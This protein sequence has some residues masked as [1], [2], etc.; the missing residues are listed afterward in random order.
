MHILMVYN[1]EN[2]MTDEK[3]PLD[4]KMYNVNRHISAMYVTGLH[5]PTQADMIQINSIIADWIKEYREEQEEKK[6][7]KKN[8]KNKRDI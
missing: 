3:I 5:K 1:E 2:G 6:H 4:E 7:E 8:L